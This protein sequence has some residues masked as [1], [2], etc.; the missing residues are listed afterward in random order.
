[1]SQELETKINERMKDAMRAKDRQ[2]S[3]L[4]RMIKSLVTERVT[5]KNYKGEEGDELWLSVIEAYVKSSKKNLS[6]YEALGAA[7]E[8]HATQVRWEIEALS[9]YLPTLADE[10][11]TQ[12]WVEEVIEALG[13]A[14]QANMGRVMG[15]V[16]KAHKGEVEPSLVKAVAQRVLG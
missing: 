14:E 9:C 7:G 11:Q 4:M 3:M 15:E 16:M 5:S 10:A 12:V 2:T 6:D 1:M 13:G 8:E